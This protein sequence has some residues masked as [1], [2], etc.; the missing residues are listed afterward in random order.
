MKRIAKGILT[1]LLLS[2]IIF[3]ADFSVG[4]TTKYF[5]KKYGELRLSTDISKD[6]FYS[7]GE[8]LID[9]KSETIINKLY[10][11]F[12]IGDITLSLGRQN[13]DWGSSYF[14]NYGNVFNNI[15]WENPKEQGKGVD[16][17]Y[18]KY[19]KG[20]SRLEMVLFQKEKENENLGI[21]YTKTILNSELMVNYFRN[22]GKEKDELLLEFKGNLILGIWGQYLV[23]NKF[24]NVGADYSIDIFDNVLYLL[25]EY[26]YKLD[27]NNKKTFNM[28]RYNL[29]ENAYFSQTLIYDFENANYNWN[30]DYSYI[31]NDYVT[32][33]FIYK[34]DNL[35]NSEYGVKMDVE[36]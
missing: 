36:F 5:Q 26:E 22:Y 24:F 27:S 13:I 31:Y 23:K 19:I 33:D 32:L 4:I 6:D 15:N 11:E 14:F 10:S 16:S 18:V 25:T 2:N 20:L 1:F 7:K 29:S 8:I 3:A 30:A 9:N 34:D 21:R 17:L 12:Y 28:Y 35:N